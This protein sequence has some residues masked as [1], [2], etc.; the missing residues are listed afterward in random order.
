MAE[1]EL[2]LNFGPAIRK[3]MINAGADMVDALP[4]YRYAIILELLKRDPLSRTMIA[5]AMGEA[6]LREHKHDVTQQ[7]MLDA[8]E[9][10][11][12]SVRDLTWDEIMLECIAE[13]QNTPG[14]RGEVV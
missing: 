9:Q 14:G 12:G 5:E 13:M 6:A 4:T 11:E 10:Q 7:A 3:A 1:L 8:T 2:E